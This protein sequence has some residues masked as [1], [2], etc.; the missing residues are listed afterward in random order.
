MGQGLGPV[1]SSSVSW[2]F[3]GGLLAGTPTH[4]CTMRLPM[5][6]KAL[7]FLASLLPCALRCVHN[8]VCALCCV[9]YVRCVRACCVVLCTC[10]L[11]C[12]VVLFTCCVALY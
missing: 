1:L 4:Y 11:C 2:R 6:E 7:P 3:A 9:V 12:A 10:V 8:A 5:V